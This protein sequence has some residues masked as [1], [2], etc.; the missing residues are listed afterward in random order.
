M[1]WI[2]PT[3]LEILFTELITHA[4]TNQRPLESWVSIEATSV[5]N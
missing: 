1:S 4:A 2:T 3:V 5:K